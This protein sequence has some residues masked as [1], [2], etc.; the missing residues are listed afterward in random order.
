MFRCF[1]SKLYSVASRAS[2][3]KAVLPLARGLLTYRTVPHARRGA[4]HHITED[5]KFPAAARQSQMLW[6]AS[7]RRFISVYHCRVEVVLRNRTRGI[8]NSANVWTRR[9]RGSSGQI[10]IT[11]PMKNAKELTCPGSRAACKFMT[12]SKVSRTSKPVSVAAMRFPAAVVA[13]LALVMLC[14]CSKSNTPE[15]SVPGSDVN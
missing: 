14:D 8:G 7:L 12:P 10:S 3:S 9:W 4:F 5:T 6:P 11:H 1:S 15:T 2:T 13:A